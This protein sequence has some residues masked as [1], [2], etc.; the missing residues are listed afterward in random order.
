MG[1]DRA[2]ASPYAT[3]LNKNDANFVPLTPLSFLVRAAKVYP[4]RTA[5][6]HGARKATYREFYARCRRLGS[7]L[8]KR[9][10]G[11]GDTVAILS[12]NTPAMLEASY[13]VAMSGAVLN[14]LN[15]R[16]DAASLA[17]ILDHAEANVLLSDR[18]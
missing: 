8:A 3:G 9:G 17:F 4:A 6:I 10:I 18:A 13:G 16:L 12:P 1:Q 14:A 15:L 2:A 5:Y 7:A 11:E